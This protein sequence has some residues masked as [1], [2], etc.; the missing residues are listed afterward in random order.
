MPLGKA[1]DANK[2]RSDGGPNEAILQWSPL[3]LTPPAVL[4][5]GAARSAEASDPTHLIQVPSQRTFLSFG[6]SDPLSANIGL[7][8]GLGALDAIA[9]RQVA[10]EDLLAAK[11]RAPSSKNV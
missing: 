5:Q 11:A 3:L 4:A 9:A 6:T 7:G 8:V 10:R 1:V 2:P